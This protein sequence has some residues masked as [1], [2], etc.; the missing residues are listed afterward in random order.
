MALFFA[1]IRFLFCS[2]TPVAE[3]SSTSI[4]S[5]ILWYRMRNMASFILGIL[6]VGDASVK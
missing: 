1:K 3:S 4:P 2:T 5:H 6:L